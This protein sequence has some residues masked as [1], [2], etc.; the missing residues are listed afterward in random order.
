MLRSTGSQSQDM[1]ERLTS[2][3]RHSHKD[4][5]V[6]RPTG[7]AM[8][9][10][11]NLGT[12]TCRDFRAPGAWSKGLQHQPP[13]NALAPRRALGTCEH[14]PSS[15]STSADPPLLLS[16]PLDTVGGLGWPAPSQATLPASLF[17]YSS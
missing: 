12:V 4:L 17:L 2:S 5:R 7:P 6:T 16:R 15:S 13:G 3:S 10:G 1:T 8:R 14:K 11:H 9:T